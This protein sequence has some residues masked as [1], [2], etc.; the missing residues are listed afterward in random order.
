MYVNRIM[1]LMK[2]VLKGG[3]RRSNREGEFDQSTLHVGM[4]IS[5]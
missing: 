4:E 5:Q 3:I 1:K 2:I